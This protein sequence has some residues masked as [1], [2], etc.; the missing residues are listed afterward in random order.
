[1]STS[2]LVHGPV[3]HWLFL[4]VYVDCVCRKAC[5]Y[6]LPKRLPHSD[7][8]GGHRYLGS[9]IG[10]RFFLGVLR[11]ARVTAPSSVTSYD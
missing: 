8:T 2:K 5:I 4:L 7:T 3:L 10:H 9:D 6:P 1:M 11:F